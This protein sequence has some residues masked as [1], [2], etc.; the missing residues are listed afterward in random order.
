M[1]RKRMKQYK[2]LKF[3]D[4]FMF[5]K[6]MEDKNLCREVLECLLEREIGEISEIQPQRE[7]RYTS[8]GK[9]VRLD[10]YN[11]DENDVIYDAEMENLNHKTVKAHE[12]PKR[13]RF[14]QSAIDID[15]MNRGNMYYNLPDS[16][17]IFICTFDPFGKNM[18]K[19]TFRAGCDEAQD[20]ALEDGAVRIF[21]NG[22]YE[23]DDISDELRAF[24]Q[25][26]RT[27]Q[28]CNELTKKIDAAVDKGRKNEVWRTQ[29]M[30]EWVIYQDAKA[31][32]REEERIEI[33]EGLLARGKTP[34]EI[35]DFIGYPLDMILEMKEKLEQR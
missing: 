17:I 26:L 1:E 2:E 7:F 11:K 30:K 16:N 33:V 32:G 31:E 9:P 35:S 3:N 14:Y 27:G 18:A 13:S 21:F 10:V 28:A 5:G 19:Y 15:Y 22:C 34:E 24:Y 6:V 12:L 25:Y 23:G 20:V 4:D 8:D 29:Y